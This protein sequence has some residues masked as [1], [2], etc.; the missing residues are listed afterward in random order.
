MA[1]FND[2]QRLDFLMQKGRQIVVDCHG[3]NGRG[4]FFYSLHVAE[5]IFEEPMAKKIHVEGP[6]E[7]E[8]TPEQKRQVIDLAMEVQ[9]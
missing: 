8:P 6:D 5:G 7:F 1:D 2:T 4:T 9:P 3:T